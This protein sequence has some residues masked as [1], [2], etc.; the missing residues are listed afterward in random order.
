MFHLSTNIYGAFPAWQILSKV[1]DSTLSIELYFDG[2]SP[3][4]LLGTNHSG[5]LWKWYETLPCP[6]SHLSPI[7]IFSLSLHYF[8]Y[9]LLAIILLHCPLD[10]GF[11]FWLSLHVFTSSIFLIF[12]RDSVLPIIRVNILIENI[13]LISFIIWPP[14]GQSLCLRCERMVCALVQWHTVL[15]ILWLGKCIFSSG[16]SWC[17]CLQPY[18]FYLTMHFVK[19]YHEGFIHERFILAPNIYW[20][21][22]IC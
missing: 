19:K 17:R 13:S 16:E 21:L 20:V 4:Q 5:N 18:S 10:K 7:L 14:T 12:H 3:Q 15:Y 9:N 1:L 2:L 6:S 11:I 8:S 22:T